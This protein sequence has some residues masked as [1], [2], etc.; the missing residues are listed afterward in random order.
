MQPGD[1]LRRRVVDLAR[2]VDEVGGAAETG[3]ESRRIGAEDRRE[4]ARGSL[5]IGHQPRIGPHG[6]LRNGE[7]ELGAVAIEDRPSLGREHDCPHALRLTQSGVPR[8]VD[9]LQHPDPH[10]HRAEREHGDDERAREPSVWTTRMPRR[11]DPVARTALGDDPGRSRLTRTSRLTL[12][13]RRRCRQRPSPVDLTEPSPR[14]ASAG[15]RIGRRRTLPRRT[16]CR[17]G[18]PDPWRSRPRRLGRGSV[19]C[20]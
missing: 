9:G 20:R 17:R 18:A 16:L 3:R 2:D 10:E 4:Q 15:S 14:G 5:R 1:T 12:T 7:R 19:R 8:R 6:L 11:A 13:D